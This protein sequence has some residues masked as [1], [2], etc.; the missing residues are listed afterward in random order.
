MSS[1]RFIL[2]LAASLDFE[3]TQLDVKSAYLYGEVTNKENLY[4]RPPPGNL[5][6]NLPKGHVLKLK[7][8]LYGLKQ[9]GRRWYEKLCD[10]LINKLN[11]TK[12]SY[13]NAVFYRYHDNKL[14]LILCCHV[15]DI[16]LCTI[17]NAIAEAFVKALSNYV[18]V[19]NGGEIHWILGIEIQ[20]DRNTRTIKLCQKHYIENIIKRYNFDH[21]HACHT[22]MQTGQ[23]LSP[24]PSSEPQ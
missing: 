19:T 18:Q 1:T 23:N 17:N 10:I 21:L 24:R 4:L 5:L 13:D 16:T 22:P 7:K 6:P 15:D 12:S 11:L 14:I 20:R 9:A 3:I 2:T 8:T